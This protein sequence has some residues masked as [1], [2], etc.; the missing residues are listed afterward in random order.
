MY[1]KRTI[2]D[3]LLPRLLA[4]DPITAEDIARSG[5]GRPVPELRSVPLAQLRLWALLK[6]SQQSLSALP[7]P[8]KGELTKVKQYERK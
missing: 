1:A 2:F 3:L 6:P 8:T 5:R 4:D 7:A